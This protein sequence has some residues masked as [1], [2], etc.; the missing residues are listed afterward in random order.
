MLRLYKRKRDV[1]LITV[2][3]NITDLVEDEP[4]EKR[5]LKGGRDRK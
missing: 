4:K 2:V 1:A 5:V 3:N